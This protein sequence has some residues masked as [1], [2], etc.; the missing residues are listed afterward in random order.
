MTNR[1]S[2]CA[3]VAALALGG[4]ACS[5]GNGKGNAGQGGSNGGSSGT[6]G[7]STTG[8][9]GGST[10]LGGSSGSTGGSTG[11]GGQNGGTGGAGPGSGGSSAGGGT[12]TAGFTGAGGLTGAGN[13]CM[14]GAPTGTAPNTLAVNVDGAATTIN[15]EIF[16][17]LMERLGRDITGGLFVGTTSSIPNT[18]GMRND[19]IQG[20]ID[21]GV[22]MIEW[23]GGCAANNYNFNPPNPTNDMGTDRYMQL[24]SILGISP[25]IAGG[26]T[27]ALAARNLQW[28]TYIN[29]NTT[30]PEWNLQYFKIGNEVWGCG[31]N[32]TEA[33]YETNYAA[34]V[35]MLAA[36]VNGKKTSLIASTG[37]IG[38][39]TWLTT[40]LMNQAAMIDGIEVH[41]YI[42]HPNDIPSTGYTDAQY[43]NVVN[44]ANRGQ[45]GPRLTQYTGILDQFDPQKRIKIW[46]DEWG[47]WLEPV[48]SAT[49]GFFQQMTLMDAISS[50]EQ[51]HLFMQH[52]DRVFMGGAAQAVNVIHALF[53]TRA[54]DAALVKTPAFYVFKMFIPHHS[55]GA[56]W[57]P[58]TLTS[59]NITGNGATFPVLSA[60]TS[61]DSAGHVNISLANVDL[62]NTHAIQINLTSAKAGYTVQSA[63][64]ITGPAKD[65]FNDFNQSETVNIQ[66]LAASNCTI[67]GKSLR[68]TLPA[69]SVAM[70]VLSPQ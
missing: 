34:N 47:D 14:N 68:V 13:A 22:G 53:F 54:T 5:S 29:N 55:G 15:K 12:G 33:T 43:Y 56:K 20:F 23:P 3:V 61:V 57:A 63:Q 42:Y 64:V 45:I 9:G 4:A 62:V 16:G 17:V 35:S 10:G 59:E 66:T 46:E 60:G 1:K 49:D 24:C 44:A 7:D 18:N 48:N 26:G 21:A 52:A 65:S 8:A 2:L 38:N 40:Q 36:P 70:L 41:D 58:N 69:R 6:G 37:L 28:I 19:I 27:A 51:L 30:H 32:Q 25:Y 11:S 67:S 50:A 39:T 31:G